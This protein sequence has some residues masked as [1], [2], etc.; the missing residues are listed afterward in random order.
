M[1]LQFVCY[2]CVSPQG[3]KTKYS[4]AFTVTTSH[5]F[6]LRNMHGYAS[7]T[8]GNYDIIHVQ[9]DCSGDCLQISDLKNTSGFFV[10]ASLFGQTAQW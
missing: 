7:A 5:A 4:S 6:E 3:F 10:F 9:N 2:V 1:E 8:T